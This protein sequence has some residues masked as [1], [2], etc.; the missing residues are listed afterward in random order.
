MNVRITAVLVVVLSVFFTFIAESRADRAITVSREAAFSEQRVALVIGNGNYAASPLKNPVNDAADMAKKLEAMGF[1]VI[2][3]IDADQRS[4]RRAI[5][6][7]GSRLK[8]GGVGLFYFAGHGMQVQGRNYLIPVGADIRHEDEVQDYAVDAGMVL[9]KMQSAENRLN[10][11]LLDACRNN[12]FARS[13]RSA[14]RG[15]A[16]MDAPAGSMISYATA[17]G[18]TAMDGDGRNGVFTKHLLDAL[19]RYGHLEL[20][21][22]MKQVGRGVQ[23]ETKRMQVPW[24][25]SSITGDFFFVRPTSDKQESNTGIDQASY[26]GVRL[27]AEEEFWLAI[28][29]SNAAQDFKDYLALYPKGRFSSIAAVRIRQLTSARSETV[30]ERV[31]PP[32]EKTSDTRLLSDTFDANTHGWT[33][34]PNGQHYTTAIRD[35]GFFMQTKNALNSVEFMGHPLS[36]PER[37]DVEVRA[38]WLDGVDNRPFGLALG[39]DPENRLNFA[40]SGNGWT[41]VTGYT[42]NTVIEPIPLAWAEGTARIGDGRTANLLKI[43]VRG[44]SCT[45]EVNG[46]RIGSVTLPVDPQR[47]RLGF[48]VENMQMI[49]FDDLTVT[50][51]AGGRRTL[52]H[53]AFSIDE[54]RWKLWPD[55]EFYNTALSDGVYLMETKNT[56]NSVEFAD[57]PLDLPDSFDVRVTTTWKKGVNNYAYG[58]ALGT[59]PP[60]RYNFGISANGWSYVSA[61]ANNQTV[62][63]EPMAWTFGHVTPGNGETR[64]DLL[65]RV[66]GSRC[67]F[68]VNDTRVGQVFLPLPHHA[69]RVGLFV[70]NRQQVAFDDLDVTEAP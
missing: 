61:H 52:F 67:D 48:F 33:L 35:G 44:K 32:P 27:D 60:N 64:N 65:V 8:K 70:E 7:F 23:T 34:W 10:I 24:V 13:F 47:L 56:L 12:P 39:S 41:N 59:D 57:L 6:D 18:Q 40:V 14:D 26:P 29:Q 22:M 66:R 55:G 38:T 54:S 62:D 21:Q 43:K 19:D 25:S 9:R 50:V 5:R 16:Q 2:R 68:F 15:L 69:L 4:M 46:N 17:P 1:E 53:E 58:L 36:L 11:V 37:F 3:L 28:K 51:P 63:P 30:P 20:S 42:D 31:A 45:Y 49:R